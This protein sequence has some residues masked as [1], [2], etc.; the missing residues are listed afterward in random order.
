MPYIKNSEYTSRPLYLFNRHIETI[1]PSLFFKKEEV[2]YQREKINL[3][4]GDF[5]NL[6]WLT[7]NNNRL[8]I[9]CHGMEGSSNRHYIKRSA[10]YFLKRGWD[11]LAWNNR[12]C[13]G[14][15]NKKIK[16]YHH[17]EIEDLSEV[18]DY[19]LKNNTYKSVVLLGFSMG[20]SMVTKY[21]GVKKNIDNRV[22]GAICFSVSNDLKDTVTAIED[23]I[24][25]Y[26]NK[27]LKKLKGKLERKKAVF[28][29]LR[30][31]DINQ[32]TSLKEYY[33]EYILPYTGF[34]TIEDFYYD[35]SCINF[36]KEIDR[37]VLMINAKNDPL[38]GP[39]CFPIMIAKNHN[40]L[41]LETPKHGGHLGFSI[42]GKDFSYMEKR[43][44]T[45][46]AQEMALH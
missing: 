40:F 11:V 21:L 33:K 27:F 28:S 34:N 17:G 16:T 14:E 43:A 3:L 13:G 45:F 30:D 6:D 15:V 24:S 20:G 41:F 46:M 31:V 9:M 18:I 1:I 37:P 22:K 23:T 26:R 12:G 29:E 19:A 38:L 25:I 10:N 42:R 4:D 8:L 36:L 39:N 2:D 7:N 35:A 5:L 32:I 44:E